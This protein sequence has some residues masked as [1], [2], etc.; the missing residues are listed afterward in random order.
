MDVTRHL[1]VTVN[2]LRV[3]HI[4][5]S[6]CNRR[7]KLRHARGGQPE[8]PSQNTLRSPPSWAMLG[9]GVRGIFLTAPFSYAAV[10]FSCGQ[11]E[12][13]LRH[14]KLATSYITSEEHPVW[15]GPRREAKR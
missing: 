6:A 10:A 12:K 13:R 7:R 8:N 2:G 9:H 11:Y 5:L 14:G 4:E 1:D 3:L 15:Q